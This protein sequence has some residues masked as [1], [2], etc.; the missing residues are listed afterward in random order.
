MSELTSY[1]ERYFNTLLEDID[2]L[3]KEVD[4]TKR[5]P[6]AIS[7]LLKLASN[8]EEELKKADTSGNPLMKLSVEARKQIDEI[9]KK[10]LGQV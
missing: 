5:N 2:N 10:D 8:A 1:Y 6:K 9:I 7:E 3:L 4:P